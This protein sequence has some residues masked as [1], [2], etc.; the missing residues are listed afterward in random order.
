MTAGS[1]ELDGGAAA[2][3]ILCGASRARAPRSGTSE[4]R[5]APDTPNATSVV[6]NAK[7]LRDSAESAPT[8]LATSKHRGS[9]RMPAM[10]V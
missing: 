3:A 5:K 10:A 7:V 4:S 1:G 6:S 2:A 9:S 8:K